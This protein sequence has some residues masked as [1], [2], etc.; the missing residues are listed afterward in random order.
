MFRINLKL[1]HQ[2]KKV[3]F[4]FCNKSL[5]VVFFL[6]C[7]CR[8]ITLLNSPNDFHLIATVDFCRK[9]LIVS[10]VNKFA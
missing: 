3:L 9:I 8:T 1:C 7:R 4:C 6:F 10:A 2:K 5:A